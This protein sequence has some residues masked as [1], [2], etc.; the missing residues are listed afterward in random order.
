MRS[1]AGLRGSSVTSNR[2]RDQREEGKQ[3]TIPYAAATFPEANFAVKTTKR[4]HVEHPADRALQEVSAVRKCDF[5][6]FAIRTTLD[7][8][9]HDMGLFP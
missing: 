2:Q 4:A 9:K 8:I 5:S 3:F 6:A 1:C 7:L